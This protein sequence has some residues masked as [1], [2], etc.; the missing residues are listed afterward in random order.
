LRQTP[1]ERERNDG[2]A[3]L[4]EELL[5]L[6]TPHDLTR[7]EPTFG[8]GLL[9][10]L[11]HSDPDSQQLPL[12]LLSGVLVLKRGGEHVGECLEEE[13]KDELE[14]GDDDEDGEGDQTEEVAGRSLELRGRR[15][16]GRD[17]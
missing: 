7:L 9:Q 16:K 3:H 5:E 15:K 13:G 2:P 6:V 10:E 4:S 17:G 8:D 12:L 14:S 1:R 11:G